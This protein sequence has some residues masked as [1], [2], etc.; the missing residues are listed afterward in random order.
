MIP[1]DALDP[2]TL[3]G[4]W[5]RRWPECPPFTHRLLGPLD[6][7][8]LYHPYD[9]GADVI[10]PTRAARDALKGRHRDWL[11]AHSLGL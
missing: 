5:E 9:G 4:L 3:T 10:G 7:R 2:R 8:W 6:A 11:S 1:D